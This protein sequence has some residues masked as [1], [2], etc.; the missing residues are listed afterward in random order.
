MPDRPIHIA[1]VGG[2]L[3][4]CSLALGLHLLKRQDITFDVFE[5]W[6]FSERGAGV[7]VHP[8]G[9]NSL[10]ELG[11]D[12]DALLERAGAFREKAAEAVV[13]CSCLNLVTNV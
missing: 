3:G 11:V 5:A 6:S 8:N 12:A 13:V 1:I 4:G 9:Q 10:R 2:S 7:G